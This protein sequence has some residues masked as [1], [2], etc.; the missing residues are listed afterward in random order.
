[1][2]L[3]FVSIII[4]TYSD[5]FRLSLCLRSLAEQTYPQGGFEVIVVNNK[6]DDIAPADF[7]LHENMMLLKEPKPGSYAAR[8]AALAVAKGSII[9]FTDSDCVIDKDWI[10]NAV[11][12]FEKHNEVHRIGGHIRIFFK[13]PRPTNIELHDKIF[14]FPQESCVKKGYAVTGNMFSRRYVFDKIGFFNE[15]LLSGGDYQWG[16]LAERNGFNIVYVDDVVVNHPARDTLKELVKKEKRIGK[17][18]AGFNKQIQRRKRDGFVELMKLAKPRIWEIKIIFEK[19]RDLDLVNK[20]SLVLIRH[21][22][23]ITGDITRI[24]HSYIK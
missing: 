17:G 2:D 24:Y 15:A 1:M 14:A 22:V 7:L 18:Q 5:W 3:P 19:G 23:K 13:G 8:N 4:P 12:L 21:Y 6:I 10:L 9:G 16:M 11:A 20:L